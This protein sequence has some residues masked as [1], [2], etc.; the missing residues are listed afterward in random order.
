MPGGHGE[1]LY[2]ASGSQ[3][4]KIRIWK[5]SPSRHSSAVGVETFQECTDP[6]QDSDEDEEEC[7]VQQPTLSALE[8][9]TSEARCTFL[10]SQY[11]SAEYS[12]SEN[13]IYSVYLETLLVGHE[14]WVTS[15]HWMPGTALR[16]FTTSMDRNMVIWR[17]DDIEGV[18][19]PT[20]RMGDIGGNLGGSVGGNLLGFVG[21]CAGVADNTESIIGIGYG[22]SFHLWQSDISSTPC[23]QGGEC[24]DQEAWRPVPFITGHFGAVRDVIWGPNEDH[25]LSVSSDQTCRLFAPVRSQQGMWRELSRP[26]IHGYDL[27]CIQM[28][29]SPAFCFYSGGDE[30]AIRAFQAPLLVLEGLHKLSGN[31]A[32]GDVVKSEKDGN[33]EGSSQRIHSAYIPELGLS[34][35]PASQMSA[36]EAKEQASRGVES[37][38]WEDVPLE[39]QLADHTIWPETHKMHGH[40]GDVVCLTASKCGQWIASAAKGRDATSSAI[41]VWETKRMVCVAALPGHE[42]TV[43]ALEFSENS[44]YLISGGKDRALCM[45]EATPG[46]PQPFTVSAFLRSAHKRIIWDVTWFGDG[47]NAFA[48]ASRDG[49]VKLWAVESSVTSSPTPPRCEMICKETFSPFSGTAVTAI[50]GTKTKEVEC[51]DVNNKAFKGWLLAVGG[52]CGG[53]SIWNVVWGGPTGEYT[54]VLLHNVSDRYAHGASVRCLRW[55]EDFLDNSNDNDVELSC[56]DSGSLKLAS[57]GDD[58]CVRVFSICLH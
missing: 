39:G 16:L 17:P 11:S 34:N 3:D 57:G 38:N 54:A 23:G 20:T 21:G 4:S 13:V 29:H 30:K 26:Q 36:D 15:V 56:G 52:E 6:N 22:G 33:H 40:R 19:L 35:K 5:I 24:L 42:S 51:S 2:F 58:H 14:D 8:D 9:N 12:S 10:S 37:L 25:V 50:C 55:K 27:S 49:H 46:E 32:A 31:T 7:V 41:L 1:D 45:Y 53:V 18:W 47:S 28:A 48:T 44:R 43:T